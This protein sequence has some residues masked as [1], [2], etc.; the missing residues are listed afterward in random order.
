MTRI[1]PILL[2]IGLTW[3]QDVLVAVDGKEYKGTLS[4][5]RLMKQKGI[6]YKIVKKFNPGTVFRI[7]QPG[8][9]LHKA[10]VSKSDQADKH[11]ELP[12]GVYGLI[13]ESIGY[14]KYE[15][16]FEIKHDKETYLG[17]SL[18]SIES[19]N[20]EIKSLKVKRNLSL[21]MTPVLFGVGVFFKKT[22]NEKYN[23]YQVAGSDVDKYRDEVELNDMYSSVLFGSAGL[24]ILPLMYYQFKIKKLEPTLSK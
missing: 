21:V 3:G 4:I 2:F 6:K 20:N 10:Y 8:K 5:S 22:A 13:I 12:V 19:I 14:L 17:V 23:S 11:W 7:K 1:F 18:T 15:T 9:F 24:G 16:T